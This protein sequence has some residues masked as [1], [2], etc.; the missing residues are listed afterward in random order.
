MQYLVCTGNKH[1]AHHNKTQIQS[2]ISCKMHFQESPSLINAGLFVTK[3]PSSQAQ[4][5]YCQLLSLS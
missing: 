2:G 4:D 3:I 1:S 5:I